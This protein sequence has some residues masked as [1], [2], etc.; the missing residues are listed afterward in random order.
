MK[1]SKKPDWPIY[2]L[3]WILLAGVVFGLSKLEA[4]EEIP[5]PTSSPSPRA[6]TATTEVILPEE[7]ELVGLWVPYFELQ[8]ED[9]E[10]FRENFTAM[11]TKAEKVGVNA[12]FVH[13]RAF[14]D[15]LYESE[16]Y[17]TSHLIGGEQGAEY[18]FDPLKFMV[19]ASHEKGMEFH[20][21]INPLR[22]AGK[23]TPGDFSTDSIY[24]S[25]KD[26]CPY[27]FIETESG[28]Y[29]DPAYSYVRQIVAAGAE[30]IA[31]NYEV[32]GIHFDDYFYPSDMG[33]Q[34]ELAYMSYLDMAVV[35][36]P[37]EDWRIA[38]INTM[39]SETY[40]AIKKVNP[41]ISFGISPQGNIG[42]NAALGADVEAWCAVPGYVD[43][44][45][46]QI[47]FS[48]ENEALGFE[49][50]L[51]SWTSMEKHENLKIYIGLA[52]Y[53]AGTDSDGGTWSEDR[54]EILE[55]KKKVKKAKADGV[56][57]FDSSDI[58]ILLD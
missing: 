53:K 30:E 5:E 10:E 13:V 50:C 18:G 40:R 46:P 7:S 56:V 15:A 8:A 34:D 3:L 35:P 41:E 57:Y 42:N 43:Y 16:I 52:L 9:E 2:I 45:C 1:R 31:E 23:E 48:F 36:L 20:A 55:Q 54:S 19:E 51:D 27:Y 38:N 44:I 29:L 25:L 32:D 37:V 12:L 49:E 39:V 47:Y 11:V 22:V 4:A 26:S 21:W 58:D 24:S 6:E 17:P 33:N 14:C 28:I